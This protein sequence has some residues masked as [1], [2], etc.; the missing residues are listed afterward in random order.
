[1]PRSARPQR[2]P[3]DLQPHTDR[4][5]NMATRD[6][7]PIRRHS[8]GDLTGRLWRF[9]K[10]TPA[11]VVACNIAGERAD[12]IIAGG[13][14]K[15]LPTT[16]G[17]P[18]DFDIERLMKAEAGGAFK[19]G[20]QLTTDNVGRAVIA[21]AGDHIN[22][23]A[24]DAATAAGQI[25]G[26]RPPYSRGPSASLG[27]ANA[28]AAP[29][30]TVAGELGVIPIDIPDAPT[31]TYPFVNAETLEVIDLIVIKDKDGAGNTIQLKDAAGAPISDAI[32]AAVDKAVTHAGSL[33]KTKRTLPAGAG[34]QITATKLAGSMAA[35]VFLH[36]I[37]RP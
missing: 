31:I 4:S 18:I 22:A 13:F 21:G 29:A 12:G 20:D 10:E 5:K 34:F 15:A 3:L 35:Q 24:T 1:M 32:A 37:R 14:P 11:G 33:D 36:A 30:L 28:P 19:P 26:V 27:I 2:R 23:I 6:T 7:R 17:E 25:V 9:G 8:G 16:A